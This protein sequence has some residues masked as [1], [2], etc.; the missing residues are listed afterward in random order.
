MHLPCEAF[1]CFSLKTLSCDIK[2][3]V[4]P[5]PVQRPNLATCSHLYGCTRPP[6][7]PD[8]V[9]AHP[10]PLFN[11]A[12]W[13]RTGAQTGGTEIK[14][15]VRFVELAEDAAVPLARTPRR[16]AVSSLGKALC[17][18]CV[19]LRGL[20]AAFPVLPSKS[21]HLPTA[22]LLSTCQ[23]CKLIPSQL[24]TNT[25]SFLLFFFFPAARL[26]HSCKSSLLAECVK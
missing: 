12:A 6:T 18:V 14:K 26:I 22:A 21:S 5:L 11:F 20:L 15:S 25:L 13:L 2:S 23:Q 9:A 7:L 8:L 19:L 4:P 10:R 3:T 1:L 24:H 17:N 16:H